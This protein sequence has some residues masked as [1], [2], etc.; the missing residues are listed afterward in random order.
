LTLEGHPLSGAIRMMAEDLPDG[1]VHFEVR[2]Y[3]RASS[4]PDLL[5]MAAVG[6]SMKGA[7]WTTLVESVVRR[8]GGTAPRGV[9]SSTEELD[10]AALRDVEQWAEEL[11]HRHRRETSAA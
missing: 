2:T 3:T 5:A 9:E 10:D 1:A 7:A 11:V 4:L 6:E 8:S